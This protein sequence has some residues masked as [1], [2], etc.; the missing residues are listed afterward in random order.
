M[1][2]TQTRPETFEEGLFLLW[3]EEV[4]RVVPWLEI[5]TS[6]L[7]Q[8]LPQQP[9]HVMDTEFQ[10][11]HPTLNPPKTKKAFDRDSGSLDDTKESRPNHDS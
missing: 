2:N 10:P 11:G 3:C 5:E 1:T 4:K 9:N 8:T 7:S 6:Q